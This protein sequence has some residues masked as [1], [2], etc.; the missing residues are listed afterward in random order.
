MSDSH[1]R[2]KIVVKKMKKTSALKTLANKMRRRT[3]KKADIRS[4]RQQVIGGARTKKWYTQSGTP[5]SNVDC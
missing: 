5:I 2:S 3:L 1:K 4:T